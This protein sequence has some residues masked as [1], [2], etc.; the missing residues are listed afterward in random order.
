M[1]IYKRETNE[2]KRQA[3]DGFKTLSTSLSTRPALCKSAIQVAISVE[4]AAAESQNQ[5]PFESY[6]PKPYAACFM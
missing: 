4:A 6:D 5:R 1:Y 2:S 3:K